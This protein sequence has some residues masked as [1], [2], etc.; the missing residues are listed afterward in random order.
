VAHFYLPVVVLSNAT[1]NNGFRECIL[2]TIFN[3]N[4]E[5]IVVDSVGPVGRMSDTEVE[6][7]E[8]PAA[9]A[10]ENFKVFGL[11]ASTGE[12]AHFST[13]AWMILCE[14]AG[15]RA[16]PMM[17]QPEPQQKFQPMSRAKRDAIKARDSASTAVQKTKSKDE[18]TRRLQESRLQAHNDAVKLLGSGASPQPPPAGLRKAELAS[19]LTSCLK[20]RNALTALK[21]RKSALEFDCLHNPE[22]DKAA[23]FI[24]LKHVVEN[25]ARAD[26]SA[27]C[28]T[29]V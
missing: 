21:V 20:V 14:P 17:L 29:I 9:K 2:N 22:A 28:V 4:Q 25:T 13:L 7:E 26:H 11:K 5:T 8:A 15:G 3:R 23:I 19:E 6:T 12:T 16:D 24:E 18:L 1:G 10:H 27:D